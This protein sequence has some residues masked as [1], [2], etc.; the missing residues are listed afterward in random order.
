MKLSVS[1][2]EELWNR[3]L[4]TVAGDA[5]CGPSAVVQAALATALN[6]ADELVSVYDAMRP[7]PRLSYAQL[8]KRVAMLE[9][10]L[11]KENQ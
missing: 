6:H 5:R 10:L 4:T 3:T 8:E 1:V 2:P 9:A 7:A 11:L